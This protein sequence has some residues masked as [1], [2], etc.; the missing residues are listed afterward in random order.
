MTRP[1]PAARPR[2][3]AEGKLQ[4]SRRVSLVFVYVSR[5]R[6]CRRYGPRQIVILYH[7]RSKCRATGGG[8]HQTQRLRRP[9]AMGRP[10]Q[11]T[12]QQL[13]DFYN[14]MGTRRVATAAYAARAASMRPQGSHVRFDKRGGCAGGGVSISGALLVWLYSTGLCPFARSADRRVC[15]SLQYKRGR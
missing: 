3:N 13:R 1:H 10:R 5:L 9:V 6:P 7:R 12:E 2:R 8:K 14:D 15:C 11:F 4:G